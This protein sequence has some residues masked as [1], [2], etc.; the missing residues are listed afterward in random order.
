MNNQLESDLR[1]GFVGRA[2][3]VPSDSG[4]RLRTLNFQPRTSRFSTRL[5]V[6]SLTGLAAATGAVVSVVI[7]GGAQPAFAGWTADPSAASAPSTS[8]SACEAQLA[9]GRIGG[10]AAGGQWT[11]LDTDVRGP[12][13]VMVFQNGESHAT[14]F[15]GPSFT[16]VNA[17]NTA[18]GSGHASGSM[19]ASVSASGH[20][21][22]HPAR[23][24]QSQRV[25]PEGDVDRWC[26]ALR[27]GDDGVA[28]AA[29]RS[30][31]RHLHTR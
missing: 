8:A 20:G 9:N 18:D 28:P 7:L 22:A 17:A 27:S 21:A 5:T 10:S 15:T 30:W 25:D 31:R 3:Q 24:H 4:V 11:V 26:G 16:V 2:A 1:E 23:Q 12:F 29:C 13:T 19:S 6:G 14:C